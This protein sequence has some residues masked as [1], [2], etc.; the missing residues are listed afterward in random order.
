MR[1]A[2]AQVSGV[3]SRWQ[4]YRLLSDPVRLRLL[5]IAADEE[6]AMGEIAELLGESQPNVSRHA[7]PLRQAGLL[8]VR[9]QGTRSL[10]RFAVHAVDDAVVSDALRTGRELCAADG[11]LERVK[12]VVR[13]RDVRTREFFSKPSKPS[14]V[15]PVASELPAYLMALGSVLDGR[16]LAVDA[17]AGDGRSLDVLAPLFERVVALD[18][19]EAQIER[20]RHLVRQRSYANVELVCG[21]V[22]G[23]EIR[24]AV[25]S[26]ADVVVAARMLHHAAQP[27]RTLGALAGLLGSA[28]R[29]VVLDYGSYDDEAFR[30]QQADVWMGFDREELEQLAAGAGLSVTSVRSVPAGCTGDGPDRHLVWQVMVASKSSRSKR[31]P[32]AA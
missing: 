15:P 3:D 23:A 21:E 28:G 16:K 4:L 26:G 12:D 13:A 9:R 18:R 24:A 1:V 27:Q 32:A 31:S 11:S 22:D 10:V 2:S 14:G 30:E 8:E 17:G 19:S 29:V 5:A 6:L 20:A 25:G 7:A